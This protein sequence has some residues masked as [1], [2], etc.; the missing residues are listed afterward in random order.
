MWSYD[1]CSRFR[2]QCGLTIWG[3]STDKRRIESSAVSQYEELG[4]MFTV[5]NPARYHKKRSL[6]RRRR[7]RIQC[8]VH[9]MRIL[10]RSPR[11]LIHCDLQN[12]KTLDRCSRFRI[13]CDLCGMTFTSFPW[14][15]KIIRVIFLSNVFPKRILSIVIWK[16]HVRCFT[17][18]LPAFLQILYKNNFY[19]ITL[20][21]A[22]AHQ[23]FMMHSTNI[24]TKFRVE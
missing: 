23:K 24:V 12:I 2:I 22:E 10:D 11:F 13:P 8:G 3:A 20:K 19:C 4:P 18:S 21:N 7:F 15:R 14:P 16:K 17:K 1:R 5:S 6:D 9:K